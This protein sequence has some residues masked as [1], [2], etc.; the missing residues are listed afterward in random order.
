[1]LTTYCLDPNHSCDWL[2]Q[3]AFDRIR[4]RALALLF[5]V[6]SDDALVDSFLL[7]FDAYIKSP[8][9]KRIFITDLYSSWSKTA[10]YPTLRIVGMRM[11]AVHASS[12]NTERIFS[13]L[14]RIMTASRNRLSLETAFDLLNIQLAS[15]QKK[16]R[17]EFRNVSIIEEPSEEDLEDE[18]NE[19]FITES[20]LTDGIDPNIE[21]EVFV[22]PINQAIE[23]SIE[24]KKFFEFIDFEKRIVVSEPAPSSS[25][26]S[27]P[28][29]ST[30][31][32]KEALA[33]RSRS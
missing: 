13:S 11:A 19:G 14:G 23:D 5:D 15:S 1:M 4:E 21:P 25:S 16:L 24:F 28:R 6:V 27:R 17:R 32:A 2:T 9:P 30:E 29:S 26:Q 31:R 18:N 10:I 12:V 20:C 22:G 7:E 33:R 3:L 8:N